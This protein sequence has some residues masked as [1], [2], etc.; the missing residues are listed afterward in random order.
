[1]HYVYNSL[2][3][4]TTL[5]ALMEGGII[6]SYTIESNFHP[7]NR[8]KINNLTSPDSDN[9]KPI[10]PKKRLNYTQSNDNRLAAM[11]SLLNKLL[12]EDLLFGNEENLLTSLDDDELMM[13]EAVIDRAEFYF[14]KV[15]PLLVLVIP[16]V[17]FLI[18]RRLQNNRLD[19]IN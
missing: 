7:E 16:L 3:N 19:A 5:V 10:T 6:S 4:S 13:L 18:R 15:L 1:M 12:D 8:R 14:E 17:I 11:S 2:S 9:E